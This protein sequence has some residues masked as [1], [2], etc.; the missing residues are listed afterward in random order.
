MGLVFV[1]ANDSK[2]DKKWSKRVVGRPGFK[3]SRTMTTRGR[4]KGCGIRENFDM[5]I[6]AGWDNRLM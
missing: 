1:D 2:Q 4:D 5:A 6:L 3:M